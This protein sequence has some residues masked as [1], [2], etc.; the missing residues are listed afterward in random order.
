MLSLA[1][2]LVHPPR[3]LISDELS[4]GLAP[5]IIDEVYRTL[6]TIREAGTTLLIVEQLRAHALEIA[7]E[8]VVLTKGTVS[9]SGPASELD[10]LMEYLLPTHGATPSPN[11][12]TDS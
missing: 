10:E 3:L 6:A 4:L 5:I 1:R 12:Q 9:Y 7:D 2:V 8:V 11:G